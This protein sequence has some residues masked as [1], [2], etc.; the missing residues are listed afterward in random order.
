MIRPR[1]FTCE[2]EQGHYKSRKNNVVRFVDP[3]VRGAKRRV[4]SDLQIYRNLVLS[5][6]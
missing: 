2:F 6:I 5:L 1:L 4:Y 3:N